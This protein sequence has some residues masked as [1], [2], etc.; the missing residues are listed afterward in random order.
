MYR[1][2]TFNSILKL[3]DREIVKKSV[4]R[5]SSDKHSKSFNTWHHLVS[6]L[7]SQFTDC[8][9]LR[10]LENSKIYVF[11]KGYMDFNWWNKI[12]LKRSYFVTRIKK[13]NSYKMTKEL[14][15]KGCAPNIVSDKIIELTNK[16]PRGGKVNLLAGKPLRLVEVYD[17]EHKRTYQFISNL[18]DTSAEEIGD[19]YKQR[20]GVELLFKWLKQYLRVTFVRERE[21]DQDTDLY[22]DNS[23]H[24]AG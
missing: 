2:S 9:S 16:N 6:M 23:L 12:A 7:F 8:K 1:N 17:R 3:L 22:C 5:N 20:W 15:I 19:Y 11:D 14:S 10:D 18:L 21:C 24:I 13:N 4:S